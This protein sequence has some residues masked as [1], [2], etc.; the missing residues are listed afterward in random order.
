MIFKKIG[1]E[2]TR[3]IELALEGHS[4]FTSGQKH[5]FKEESFDRRLAI[6]QSRGKCYCQTS[7]NSTNSRKV[8]LPDK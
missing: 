3:A 7:G 4:L 8:L 5:N 1:E 2:C 6:A